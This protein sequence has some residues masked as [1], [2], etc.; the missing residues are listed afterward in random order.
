MAKL[1]EI[2]VT[3]LRLLQDDSR[4]TIRTLAEAVGLSPS[5]CLR[6]IQ[7]MEEAGV[8]TGYR[9]ALDTEAIGL[10][11][12]AFIRVDLEKNDHGALTRFLSEV[13]EWPEVLACY[14]ITGES[15]YL[16]HVVG[17]DLGALKTFIM[18]RL[19]HNVTVSNVN[20]SVVLDVTKSISQLP[21]EHLTTG[22]ASR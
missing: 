4:T 19:T 22:V 20:T 21:L 5:G 17:A 10:T 6:R 18:Q 3:L 8:I 16:L 1:D 11:L 12:Q 13:Q 7:V 2:D 14:A 15:D 9:A